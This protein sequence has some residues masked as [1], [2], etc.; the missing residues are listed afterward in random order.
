MAQ[1]RQRKKEE[2][3]ERDQFLEAFSLRLQQAIQESGYN[4]TAD[5]AKLAQQFGVS[6]QAVRKWLEGKTLPSS[7][8]LPEIADALGVRHGWLATGEPPIREL[9]TSIIREP[10]S[11]PCHNGKDEFPIS[12]EERLLL[13][14]Y[15]KLSNEA[16]NLFAQ[17]FTALS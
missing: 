8:R 5:Q 17:L 1:N 2:S 16:Q 15:R 3:Y 7:T 4:L 14:H 11:S 13:E 10:D 6:R 12:K 9:K